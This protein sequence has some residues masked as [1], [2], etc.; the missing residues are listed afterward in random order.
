MDISD[1]PLSRDWAEMLRRYVG[2]GWSPSLLTFMF[3]A[4][5][6][7]HVAIRRRQAHEVEKIYGRVVTRLMR[8]PLASSSVG[9]LPIWLGS[10]DVPIYK[11]AKD[12][13]RDVM[14]NDG[15]HVHVLA[16]T[17]PEVRLKSNF[18]AFVEANQRLLTLGPSCIRVHAVAVIYDVPG[19]FRYAMKTAMRLPDNDDGFFIL[20]RNASE[21]RTAP[22]R[23]GRNSSLFG[24]APNDD[25]DDDE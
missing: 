3:A 13:R 8:R 1:V 5:R 11:H 24:S 23:T 2:A 18:V 25:D 7:E 22:D 17:P 16:L 4:M 10:S 14:I 21:L 20:P 19:T 12:A 9:K 6:G 15:L